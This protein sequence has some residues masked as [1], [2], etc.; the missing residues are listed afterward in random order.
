MGEIRTFP[1]EGVRRDPL[2]QVQIPL[3]WESCGKPM[4]KKE[5]ADS[6]DHEG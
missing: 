4:P 1:V 5:D 3:L 2:Q 6:D